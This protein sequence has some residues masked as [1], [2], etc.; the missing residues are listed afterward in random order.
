[1][2]RVVWWATVHRVV[3]CQTPL[4]VSDSLWPHGL[5]HARLL[6]PSLSPWD[7]SNSYPLSGWCHPIIS[8]SVAP[9][10]SCLQ[11]FPESGSFSLNQ[12]FASGDQSIGASTSTSVLPVNIQS[13]FPL[14]LTGLILLS[15]GY[16][17]YKLDY[18]TNANNERLF[19]VT[20]IPTV[21]FIK[22]YVDRV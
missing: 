10:F 8:S 19:R 16:Q 3:K 5:Q 11:S 14:G 12:L 20:K 4:S 9:F 22:M 13:W 1:M 18:I 21:F 2:D 6:C 17:R 15:K 7:C